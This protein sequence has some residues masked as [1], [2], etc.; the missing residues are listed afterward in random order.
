MG[1]LPAATCAVFA[2]PGVSRLSL[3]V[4]FW[5]QAFEWDEFAEGAATVDDLGYDHLWSWEHPLACMGDPD[6]PTHDGYVLL[7]AWAG[8]TSNVRLGLLTGA[9]TLR[10]PGMLA[11]ATV[12]L[13]HVSGGR[14]ILGLGAGWFELEHRALGL[15]FGA[16]PGERL[17]WLEESAA[18][19]R[20]LLRGEQV[21]SAPDGRYR[22][23]QFQ[24][25]PPPV[26]ARLPLLIGGAGERRTLRTVARHADIWNM[27]G[28][29]ESSVL[30]RKVAA[31]RRHCDV[32]GREFDQI[33]RTAF[34]NPVIR[35]TERE[36]RRAVAEQA[37]RNLV[38]VDEFDGPEFVIGR[39]DQVAERI[40]TVVGAGFTTVIAQTAAPL[41]LET[42]DRL[43]GEVR[44][45]VESGA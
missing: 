43:I 2:G 30:E 44:P 1:W 10:N 22:F 15:D 13:D 11:K 19:L 25:S 7:A 28:T 34:I 18:A 20:S 26:Q 31:L 14:A 39:V 17:R 16:S 36:A 45:L 24:L 23:N 29:A 27:V 40:L 9:N 33:E 5:N 35:D 38:G 4:Q 42:I 32:E 37:A 3:G 6:Q 12:T 8:V 41:D 21:T